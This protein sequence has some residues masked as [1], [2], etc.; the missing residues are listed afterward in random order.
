[1]KSEQEF[2]PHICSI[3]PLTFA[4]PCLLLLLAMVPMQ[5]A[6]RQV[7]PGG[8]PAAV[9]RLQPLGRLDGAKELKL[10]IGLP[11]RNEAALSQMLRELYDP[12]HPKYRRYLTPGEFTAQFGPTEKDY[13]SLIGF[14]QAHGLKVRTTHSNRLLLD[15]SGSA[16]EIERAFHIILQRYQHPSEAR[17]FYAPNAEPAL[18]LATPVLGISGLSDYALPRPRLHATPLEPLPGSTAPPFRPSSAAAAGGFNAPTPNAGSGPSGTYMGADFRA[19]YAS[20][21]GL[22]GAGQTV[23]LLQFDGYSASDITY[24]EAK[25]GLPNV[26]LTNV[27]LDGFSGNPT[28]SGGEVEVCLDIEAAI[29]MAPGLSGVVVYMA[30][31]YGN[32]HDI[33]NRI[34]N[35]NLAKQISCSWYEPGGGPDPIADQIWQQMAAQGQS[36]YCACGDYDAFTGPVDFPDETPYIILVGGTTLTT[37]GPGGPWASET[38]WNWNNGIGTGG[39]ISTRYTIPAYQ[40]D[41]DMSL[42]QGSTSMRNIPDVALTAD[43]VYVRADGQDYNV[44]GTSCAAPLWAGFTA[45]VNQQA[46]GSGRPTVG[47]INPALDVLGHAAKYTTCFHDITTGNNTRSGSPTKFYAVSGYDLCTGWGTPAGQ[48]LINAL[49][50][51]DALLVSPASLAFSGNVGGPFSPSPGWLT[52]TNTGTNALDWTLANTSAWYNVSPTSGTLV[53]GGPAIP[54]SVSPSAATTTLPAGVYPATLMLTNLSSGVGQTATLALSVAAPSMKDDFDPDLDLTQWS[55]FGGMPGSTVLATNYGGSV[56]APNSL[57]FGAKGSRYAATVPIN[58]T[59]GGQIGFCLRLANGSAWP[60]AKVDNLP[61]EGIVLESSTNGGGNWTA[62]GSY[63]TPAYY[64]WTGV[65]LPIPAMAQGPAVLFRWRQSANDGTN[66]DHWALDNVV[67]GTGQVAPEIIMDPQGQ[68]VAVGNSA[69][70]SVAAIGSSPLSYQWALNGTNLA[71]ATASAF[72]LV[73]AQLS[74]GGTYSVVVSNSLG[75][76]TS[77]NAVLAVYVPVCSPPAPGLVSWWQGEGNASDWNGTNNGVLEG[78]VGFASGRVGQAFDLNGTDADVRVPASASL[79]L[80]LADGITIEAWINPLDVAQP[81]PLVE[82][83]DGD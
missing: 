3:Y 33:L 80:A 42:N 14:A 21:T 27:L 30:G 66:Y 56:S 63:A 59:A 68:S 19:A 44:G 62:L 32:W 76:A 2:V 34:A 79:N 65:A 11:L 24:Y 45:L 22:T 69:S 61:A 37:S 55:S 10:A 83:N 13:Q 46:V 4:L 31:P 82:W 60:W 77:S 73:A 15:V 54:V 18:D 9:G 38:V 57:W 12:A 58:T 47:F 48:K 74:D 26:P 35:D 67:I 23:G 71:G 52:L 39:G 28:G 5:A 1:M 75:S 20:D 50:T 81:H 53:P 64:N 17:T 7:V 25:A 40:A 6:E 41:I 70:L 78:P 29:S 72:A 8:M 36:F 43:N 16:A 51:P 49:A